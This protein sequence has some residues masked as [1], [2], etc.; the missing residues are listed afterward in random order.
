MIDLERNGFQTINRH[1]RQSYLCRGGVAGLVGDL[2]L[3]FAFLGEFVSGLDGLGYADCGGEADIDGAGGTHVVLPGGDGRGADLQL[4]AGDRHLRSRNHVH[5]VLRNRDYRRFGVLRLYRL[6]AS[7]RHRQERGHHQYANAL[8][9]RA[10]HISA[11]SVLA[12]GFPAP[13]KHK[14][15]KDVLNSGFQAL[16]KHK[17]AEIV[18]AEA[19]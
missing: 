5:G 9:H 15:V 7:A 3:E 6:V 14:V 13:E 12:G 4:A 19:G 8:P 18:L 16:N 1:G 10:E 11:R 2:E 17:N